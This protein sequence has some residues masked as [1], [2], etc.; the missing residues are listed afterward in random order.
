[1]TCCDDMHEM[2]AHLANG[3]IQV[4]ELPHSLRVSGKVAWYVYKGTYDELGTRGF[5]DFWRK[6]AAMKLKMNG[7]PGDI[8]VCSPECH[9]KRNDEKNML[10]LIWCPVE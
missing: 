2:F 5:P 3:E 7:P 8:Y 9:R 4:G 1:M 6:Y 10:T